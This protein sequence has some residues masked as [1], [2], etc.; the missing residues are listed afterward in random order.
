MSE[1]TKRGFEGQSLTGNINADATVANPNNLDSAVGVVVKHGNASY[2][3]YFEKPNQQNSFQSKHTRRIRSNSIADLNTNQY[4]AQNKMNQYLDEASKHAGERWKN[5]SG[6]TNTLVFLTLDGYCKLA[7][8]IV[9]Q[10]AGR[11]WHPYGNPPRNQVDLTI[12]MT[13]CL[14]FSDNGYG[15]ATNTGVGVSFNITVEKDPN[16]GQIY[17]VVHLESAKAKDVVEEGTLANP[18]N[19]LPI[20]Q[21]I[22]N[23]ANKWG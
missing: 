16:N 2:T 21:K 11:N 9:D 4:S 7:A 5:N 19:A 17:Y 18:K 20:G 12:T 14:T 6:K 13:E 10:A 1:T 3:V 8:Y 15:Q 22:T 23:V